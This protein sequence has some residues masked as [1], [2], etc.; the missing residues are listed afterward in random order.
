MKV[1][2]EFEVRDKLIYFY[3][4]IPYLM[5]QDDFKSVVEVPGFLIQFF[6]DKSVQ[7]FCD[8]KEFELE[9][10]E[11]FYVDKRSEDLEGFKFVGEMKMIPLDTWR[12]F[13]I[14]VE[15]NI[16][17]RHLTIMPNSVSRKVYKAKHMRV[18]MSNFAFQFVGL[19]NIIT[20]FPRMIRNVGGRFR[21]EYDC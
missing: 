3:D 12:G 5:R 8:E 1:E 13:P 14:Y 17:L 6:I 2:W 7:F 21:Y 9:G 20:R 4:A 18:I 16:V 19:R 11:R 10:G 15:T